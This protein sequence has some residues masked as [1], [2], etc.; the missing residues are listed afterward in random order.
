MRIKNLQAI[1]HSNRAT[2]L[3]F[4]RQQ[5]SLSRSDIAR[6]LG[7]SPTT[8][9]AAVSDLLG[10]GLVRESGHGASTGGRRPILLE[11]NPDGGTVISVDV[12]SAY[13]GRTIRAAALDLQ[14]EIL[15][16]IRRPIE[17]GSNEMMF[18]AVRG[19]I[20]ELIVSPAVQL[21]EAVAIG[22]GVP[23][24]VNAECGEVVFTNMGIANL[25]LGPLLAERFG[26]PVLVQNSEDAAAVGECRFGAGRGCSS[27]L[28]LSVGAGVGAGLVV[29]GQIHQRS[30]ISAGEIGHMT[31]E[32][33]G[34]RCRCGNHG[35]LSA[36]VSSDNLVAAVQATLPA[37]TGA[38][39]DVPGIL[40]AAEA[41]DTPYREVVTRAAEMIGIAIANVIN[42]L[43]PEVIVLG[44]EL[45]EESAWLFAEVKRVAHR[46]ALQD[47]LPGV[48]LLRSSLG[49]RAGL[50]GV[51]VLALDTILDPT[52]L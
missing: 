1:K 15:T 51:A 24:L 41:G 44:G 8:A 10:S 18:A 25:R 39:L 26:A 40:R 20:E 22:V 37:P 17:I 52:T 35:C 9:S 43:N 42:L 16:E 32:P 12:A 34:L 36:L 47:Y 31:I 19:V 49:R 5:G 4:I 50:Q 33:D 46:R 28:Y 6:E 48:R 29:E 30:R 14:S 27:L 38:S 11:I 3:N 23:G 13:S 45:F 2:V 7:L 21:H